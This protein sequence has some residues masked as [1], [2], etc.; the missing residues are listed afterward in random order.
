MNGRLASATAAAI[1]I[2]FSFLFAI[3]AKGLLAELMPEAWKDPRS[4]GTMS[5]ILDS[6]YMVVHVRVETDWG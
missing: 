2:R 1:S 6:L 5:G 4:E 3:L